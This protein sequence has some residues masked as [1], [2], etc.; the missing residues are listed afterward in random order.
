MMIARCVKHGLAGPIAPTA[1]RA[2]V[3]NQMMNALPIR[4]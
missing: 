4:F 3:S 2:S 1:N